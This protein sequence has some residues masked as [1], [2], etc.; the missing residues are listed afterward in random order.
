MES[1]INKLRGIIK[2]IN[3]KAGKRDGEAIEYYENGKIK[4]KTNY[5]A[6]Q[7]DG[8]FVE[9][10]EGGQLEEKA[11]YKGCNHSR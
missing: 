11:N 1:I 10:Y 5:K 6:G 3:Y 4:T 7:P 8:E 2:R 9:Y